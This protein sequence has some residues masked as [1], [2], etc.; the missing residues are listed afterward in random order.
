MIAGIF[1]VFIFWR[2]DVHKLS[3]A[4][5]SNGPTFSFFHLQ[6]INFANQLSD[7]DCDAANVTTKPKS[8]CLILICWKSSLTVQ[9]FSSVQ[10]LFEKLFN[11]YRK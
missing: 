9:C 8:D 10:S 4:L 2:I 5:N 3:E 7:G 1:F 11:H 6:E